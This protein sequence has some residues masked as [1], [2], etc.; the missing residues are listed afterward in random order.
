MTITIGFVL[1][2]YGLIAVPLVVLL[3]L[4]SRFLLSPRRRVMATIARALAV[5]LVVL[6]IA[7][8]RIGWPTDDLAVAAAI[9]G[10]LGIAPE[11]RRDLEGQLAQ[12]AATHPDVTF[13]LPAARGPSAPTIPV[14]VALG[15]MTA[16]LPRDHVRRVLLATDGR[17]EDGELA[18]AIAAAHAD[19]IEVDVLPLGAGPAID[20]V[21]IAA[22]D[23]PRL[24]HAEETLD[25]APTIFASQPTTVALEAFLDG[26]SVATSTHE[27][28]VGDS[29]GRLSVRFPTEPG[30]HELEVSVTAPGDSVSV[31]DRW[32]ALV[33]VLPKPRVR[34]YHA[35]DAPEPVLAATLREAGMEVELA[36]PTAAF[37]TVAE[38]D[39]FALVVADEIELNDFSDAQ[40]HALRSWVEDEGGGWIRVTGNRPVR[41]TPRTLREIEP[42]GPPPAQPEP[43]PLELVIVID[44]SGSMGGGPMAAARNA[45]V[46]AIRALR[47]DAMAGVVAF[48]GQAD[49]T[50]APVPM[51]QRSQIEGF[52]RSIEADGG[53]NIAAAVQAANQIMSHDD[54]FIHHVIL[55]SDG[56]SEPQS[57]TA[58]AIALAGRGVSISTITIGTYSQLL[59]DIARIGR[60]RYHVTSGGGG[61]SS[62]VVS[63]AMYRQPPA[64]RQTTFVAR[65]QTHLTMLDG[66]E[67]SG[68]PA[69]TGHALATLRPG[70]T[71]ALTATESMPLLAHWHRGL[72]QVATFTSA[73]SGSWSD[74]W[75]SA[76][77]FRRFWTSL[78]RGMLRHRTIEPPRVTI[79]RDPIDASQR[80]VTVTSPF[81]F[82]DPTPI[83]R[84]FRQR[85]EPTAL[86]LDT[87]G[88]GVWQTSVPTGFTFLVDA[89]LPLDPEPTSAAGD[90]MPY[91]EP[92]ARF[93]PDAP[94]LERLALLGGGIVVDAPAA[95]LDAPG[96]AFV[97][98]PL[99][100]AFLFAA[101]AVYLLSL[102]L[103]R[104]PDRAVASAGVVER[105]SRIPVPARA[106]PSQAPPEPAPAPAPREPD[107]QEAA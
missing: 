101:L 87:V 10:S 35:A 49:R 1:A 96:Q 99:R 12:L 2:L 79:E 105:P 68:A 73:S 44:R 14:S 24:V 36:V 91:A 100:M 56:E 60:G 33:E 107:D 102:L 82:E 81:P 97:R 16:T 15:A 40:Q 28:L 43:R 51:G 71:Q 92:L 53:T 103:V 69:L 57:A 19:G 62:L 45:A 34:I 29:S 89:R 55:I 22:L 74:G 85:T 42:I 64:H 63:E 80:I 7:D 9:D 67:F 65:E 17:D 37:T 26:H 27:A 95:I 83:V 32:R 70:A 106:R 94:M 58:A 46:A 72:G 93:G 6:A 104:L 88:P 52:V 61:L 25:I 78:A 18:S 30:V 39:R 5:A 48:S 38:Y 98:M 84:L 75:R 13:S 66:V 31:N 41:S 76:P 59:A 86:E 20:L 47:P 11:E 4:R 3:A 21:S 54:R 77:I 23:A 90:E 50:M 8:L